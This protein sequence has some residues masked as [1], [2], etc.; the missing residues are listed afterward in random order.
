MGHK[1]RSPT[2]KYNTKGRNKMKNQYL[3]QDVNDVVATD[4]FVA[5]CMYT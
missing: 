4:L 1:G 5:S 2:T 3:Q